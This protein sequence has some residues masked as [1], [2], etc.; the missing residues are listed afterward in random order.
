MKKLIKLIILTL[1]IINSYS[2]KA[3]ENISP[4]FSLIEFDP[5][6]M[7]IGS[8]S[9]S[10]TLY[11]NGL[12]IFITKK[13]DVYSYYSYF[14]DKNSMKELNSQLIPEN[15]EDLEKDYT[16]FNWTDQPENLFYFNGKKIYVYGNLRNPIENPN[17]DDKEV[18]EIYEREIELWKN[19][20]EELINTF[21]TATSYS[22]K[23]A[24]EWFPEYIEVMFWPYEY[25]PEESIIWPGNWPDL[26]DK[27]TR[28]RSEDSYSVYLPSKYYNE[29]I[30]IL[31][32]Q[33]E[34][35]AVEINNKKMAVSLRFPFPREELWLN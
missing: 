3:E 7:V 27:R 29:L 16:L 9:P 11:D 10:F 14:L 32:T 4:V 34:K 24:T 12:V 20:P 30:E 23:N 21:K 17:T 5:W 31:R 18:T 33:N 1:V 2:I 8:D 26:N 35:G 15:L 13:D 28:K 19:F 6:G 25:A 22:H